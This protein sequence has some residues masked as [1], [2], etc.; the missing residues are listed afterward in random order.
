MISQFR[1]IEPH[2]GLCA[3]TRSLL[4]ILLSAPPH[5][6]YLPSLSL[7][8]NKWTLINKR[9]CT[10]CPYL[11]LYLFLLAWWLLPPTLLKDLPKV[12][13]PCVLP[14]LFPI[15]AGLTLIMFSF[16]ASKFLSCFGHTVLSWSSDFLN[17]FFFLTL[18][19]SCRWSPKALSLALLREI[20]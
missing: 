13:M 11:S 1:G 19:S 10:N 2:V 5:S 8:I 17:S 14:P 7:R 6:H 9:L 18:V 12:T 15:A 3:S 20:P 16:F 4:G